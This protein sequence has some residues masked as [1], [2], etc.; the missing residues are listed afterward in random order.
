MKLSFKFS[1][2]LGNNT[3]ELE[4][5]PTDT[6]GTLFALLEAHTGQNVTSKTFHFEGRQLV[7]NPDVDVS[8]LGLQNGAIVTISDAAS[9]SDTAQNVPAAASS[10]ANTAN[11]SVMRGNS[12][13]P[14]NPMG[15][16]E[17][18]Y[19]S[20]TW[21]TLPPNV[22]PNVLHKI[23]SV[24]PA[25]MQELET[26]DPTLHKA[27]LE[28]TPDAL[29]NL[30]M[31]RAFDYVAPTATQMIRLTQA[32][33]RLQ[34][35]PFDIEAQRILE[36]EIT[37]RNV[38]ENYELALEEFPEA[39][40][41]VHML[42]I[43][44]KVNGVPVK[45]FVDSGA[46]S[47]IMN[48][49]CAERCGIMRLLDS[50]F[51]GKAVGVGSAPILGRVHMAPLTIGDHHLNST[52]TVLD[53]GGV[54]FLLGLD[55]LRRYQACIDLNKNELRLVLGGETFSVPFLSEKESLEAA[56][57]HQLI[58]SESSSSTDKKEP[59]TVD[60]STPGNP[61][62]TPGQNNGNSASTD[63]SAAQ[64]ASNTASVSSQAP[65]ITEELKSKVSTL[66]NMGFDEHVSLRV[67]LSVNGNIDEA[68]QVLISMA[69]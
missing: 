48:R 19:P 35:N 26:K 37:R 47:T 24:N 23:L 61:T 29:R 49:A 12:T 8:S 17:A 52:F 31:K 50:R 28:P 68:I 10:N 15:I 30:M 63:A 51:A 2:G 6:I 56:K 65:Q 27:A 46:Q 5:E 53:Q 7:M 22:A 20:L 64:A 58:D 13:R 54:E 3:V 4:L 11:T 44:V 21:K 38:M 1:P 62:S 16:D 41:T 14:A 33:R 57:S 45:A 42:Y 60:V 32:E 67:L 55:M 25:M 40:T 9:T 69:G 18:T 59:S 39:F 36:T 66:V 34:H 43:D